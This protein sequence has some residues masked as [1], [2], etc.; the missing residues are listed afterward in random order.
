[1]RASGR[2]NTTNPCFIQPCLFTVPFPKGYRNIQKPADM[3]QA[4]GPEVTTLKKNF[5][6]YIR[7]TGR[8]TQGLKKLG[9]RSSQKMSSRCV[10]VSEQHLVWCEHNDCHSCASKGTSGKFRFHQENRTVGVST[11][12]DVSALLQF[13]SCSALL[14]PQICMLVFLPVFSFFRSVCFTSHFKDKHNGTSWQTGIAESPFFIK[15]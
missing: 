9:M 5:C 12:G 15:I 4:W 7:K 13:C 1:M 11:Q 6:F 14:T 3:S 10:P 2:G 8:Q